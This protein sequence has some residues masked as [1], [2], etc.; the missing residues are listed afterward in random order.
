[1][2]MAYLSFIFNNNAYCKQINTRKT[3]ENPPSHRNADQLRN[4]LA[5]G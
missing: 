2:M 4:I 5:I 3:L 1:M